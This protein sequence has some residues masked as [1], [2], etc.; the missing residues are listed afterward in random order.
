M[1]T[2]IIHG[3]SWAQDWFRGTAVIQATIVRFVTH[4]ATAGTPNVTILI[5]ICLDVVSLGLSYFGLSVIPVPRSVS[6]FRFKTFSAIISPN[7]FL[8]PFSLF[9]FWTGLIWI[10]CLIFSQG[11]LKPF[12]FFCW[13]FFCS[14]WVIFITL[15]FRSLMHCSVSPSLLL[16]L[17]VFF[18]F[19][20]V[21]FSSDFH[22]I[23]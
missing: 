6:F 10:L 9:S 22:Y 2:H 23:F 16:M 4:C 13:F 21:F 17:P 14:A 19:V 15:S 7:T 18:I 8:T 5:M 20:I 1:A 3:I 12:S 11:S